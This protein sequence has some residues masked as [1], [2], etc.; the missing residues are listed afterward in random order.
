M[1]KKNEYLQTIPSTFPPL[2]NVLNEYSERCQNVMKCASKLECFKGKTDRD[3]F[4]TSCDDVGTNQYM[5]DNN[6]MVYF[7][8][9]VFNGRHNCTEGLAPGNLTSQVFKYEKQCFLKIVETICHPEYFNFFQKNYEDVVES[10]TTKPA[11]DDGFCAS[12][13]DKFERLQCD[14][15]ALDLR[16]IMMN[17]TILS[18]ANQSSSEIVLEVVRNMQKCTDNICLLLYKEEKNKTKELI[19][20]FEK[21]ITNLTEVFMRR[22]RLLEFKC[23][24]N[25]LL[26]DVFD[27]FGYCKKIEKNCLMPIISKMCQEEILADFE[28]LEVSV[29]PRKEV[30]N[31]PEF[32][33]AMLRDKKNHR[34]FVITMKDDKLV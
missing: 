32:E 5:F 3:V 29:G 16:S 28:N 27:D 7:L 17:M 18:I 22:P 10:Y 12:P 26:I 23:L 13:N 24:E 19:H 14:T 9:E 15:Y 8:R 21:F 34:K 2:T 31:S 20:R 1:K 33:F 4:K 25:I 11:V 30:Y 6:C